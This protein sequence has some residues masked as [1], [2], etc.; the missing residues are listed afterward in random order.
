MSDHSFMKTSTAGG[1]LTVILANLTSA[2]TIKTMVLAALGAAVSFFVSF[3]LKRITRKRK[4]P[5]V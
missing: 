5:K 1:T 2:D 4:D 3:F